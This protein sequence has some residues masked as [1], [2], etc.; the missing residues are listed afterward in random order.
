MIKLKNLFDSVFKKKIVGAAFLFLLVVIFL[1]ENLFAKK[2]DNIKKLVGP[3]DSVL[4]ADSQNKIIFSVNKDKKLI[5]ASV[6]KLFTALL[7]F[8]CLGHDYRFK[9]EF[10]ID[11]NH[12]LTIKGYGDPLLISE[13]IPQI[14]K[15]LKK[16]VTRINDIVLDSSWFDPIN[17]PGVTTSLNPYDAPNG[18]LC[19]NFNTVFFKRAGKKYVSAEPQTPLLDFV[20]PRIKKT[21]L[22][23]G[24]IILSAQNNETTLYAG[25]IFRYFMK[26]QKIGING[27]IRAGKV[28]KNRDR[29]IFTYI[30]VFPMDIAVKKLLAY[31]NNFIANQLFITCGTAAFGPPGTLEKGILAAKAFADR[32]IGKGK[33]NIAEGSGISRKNRISAESVLKILA[34]FEPYKELMRKQGNISYKTGSLT[35]VKT[36]AGYIESK[37]GMVYRFV[38]MI[39]TKGKTTGKIMSAL[40]AAIE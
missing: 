16:K 14:V 29:L 33:I 3:H 35:G 28:K 25:H 6:F 5:P 34:L 27:K 10:Y 20:L 32:K 18:A 23:K 4:L 26:K 17:I 24:R 39:N 13:I 9:T 8:D 15:S 31:S 37:T 12:N 1:P 21:G 36:K 2:W 11:N 40:K 30:S 19:V 7:V 22:K 38:I